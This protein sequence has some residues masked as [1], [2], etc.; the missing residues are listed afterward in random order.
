[1]LWL[2]KIT[3]ILLWVLHYLKN[4][5]EKCQTNAE[6]TPKKRNIANFS[7]M[8]NNLK[9]FKDNQPKLLEVLEGLCSENVIGI[10]INFVINPLSNAKYLPYN[11]N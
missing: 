5:H 3:R 8:L 9:V 4:V 2:K 10:N 6:L 11:H 1:M 7:E